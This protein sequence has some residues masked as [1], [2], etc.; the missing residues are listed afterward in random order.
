M[1]RPT[2]HHTSAG[3]LPPPLGHGA[4]PCAG[5]FRHH[6]ASPTSRGAGDGAS[7]GPG[8]P[9]GT[10]AVADAIGPPNAATAG[11]AGCGTGAA[12]GAGN[13]VGAGAAAAAAAAIAEG[14]RRGGGTRAEEDVEEGFRLPARR[15][16]AAAAVTA[17]A[18]AEAE[19]EVVR[20]QGLAQ[21]A[22]RAGCKGPCRANGSLLPCTSG[23]RRSEVAVVAPTTATTG[24]GVMAA[25]TPGH[26]P[27]RAAASVP[28]VIRGKCAPHA[29][30]RPWAV[31]SSAP[32]PRP[33]HAT[34]VFSTSVEV[35]PLGRLPTSSARVAVDRAKPWR[36]RPSN[37][38]ARARRRSR[39]NAAE[40][41]S[42]S[43]S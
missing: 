32:S 29:A 14:G 2:A 25:G 10:P 22:E 28:T 36:R 11:C 7:G 18:A 6:T 27:G 1:Q 43:I 9:G 8:G 20:A 15:Q 35:A 38:A 26:H 13:V 4:A 37:S 16:P 5:V 30:A 24:S 33:R 12:G 19:V 3:A 21:E 17:A 41:R 23:D 39:P 40:A 31:S 34:A 42:A